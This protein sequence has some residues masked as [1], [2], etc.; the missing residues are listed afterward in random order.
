MTLKSRLRAPLLALLAGLML[1]LSFP[2]V[3]AWPLAW[4]GLVPLLAALRDCS[5]R[6]GL[7]LGWLTGFVTTFIGLGW[8]YDLVAPFDAVPQ[9]LP[10]PVA[11]AV[12]QA[13]ASPS[14]SSPPNPARASA[15][16][17]TVLGP[18]GVAEDSVQKQLRAVLLEYRG[19][20]DVGKVH[21]LFAGRTALGRST[22]CDLVLDDQQASKQHAIVYLRGDDASFMDISS[23]G[24]VVDGRRLH[25]A[26]ASLQQGSTIVIGG[27]FYV[28]LYVSERTLSGMK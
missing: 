10:L 14:P 20:H 19:R 22:D 9:P 15:P 24:S 4:L 7:C 3:S 2:P 23:N 1:A 12:G 5:P 27:R 6:Q 16:Q 11:P 18:G 13:W 26:Q 25:G 8:I 17:H 21:P 28:F